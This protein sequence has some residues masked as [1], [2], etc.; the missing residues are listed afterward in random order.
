[1]VLSCCGSFIFDFYFQEQD[2]A[3]SE[4]QDVKSISGK[5]V[6]EGARPPGQ[7]VSDGAQPPAYGDIVGETSEKKKPPLTPRQKRQLKEQE[8]VQQ[9]LKDVF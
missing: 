1:M 8:L 9:Y 3:D 7:D 6:P 2:Y 4:S 5:D